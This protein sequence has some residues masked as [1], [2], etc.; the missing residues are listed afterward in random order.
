MNNVGYRR[1]AA[2]DDSDFII[3]ENP[4]EEKIKKEQQAKKNQQN[5]KERSGPFKFH[6]K[7]KENVNSN[8]YSLPSHSCK[9]EPEPKLSF[10]RVIHGKPGDNYDA[11]LSQIKK[12]NPG[13]KHTITLERYGWDHRV[14][15]WARFLRAR[16]GIVPKATAMLQN[17]EAWRE[18]TFPINLASKGIKKVFESKSISELDF[19]PEIFPATV[20][21][22]FAKLTTLNGCTPQN[23]VD[24]F[25]IV[26]ETLLAKAI[27]PR[28]P[29]TCQFIDMT[30]IKI[31]A[32]FKV[33]ILKKIYSGT[34]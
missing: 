33:A 21:V 27:C 11:L 23:V 18:R 17:H 3:L 2:P 1:L 31:S 10:D 29:K 7:K 5:G 4:L 22:N 9:I 12:R 26:T 13:V 14:H 8:N 32:G 16:N 6:K 24:A 20:Y 25:V 28:H 19:T 30:D 34:S 15:S